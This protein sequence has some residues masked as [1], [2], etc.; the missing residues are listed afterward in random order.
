MKNELLILIPTYNEIKNVEGILL[1]ILGLELPADILFIDDNS[2]DGTGD[3]LERLAIKY[4]NIKILHRKGKLGIGS[5]HMDGINFAYD[6]SYKLL[7]TMDC[8]FSHSPKEIKNFIKTAEKFDIVVGSRFLKKESLKEWNFLRLF[9][10]HIGHIA[11]RL[12]LKMPYDSTGAFRLYR[13]D[14]I[15]RYFLKII[16]SKG[17]SF[18]YESLYVLYCNNYR[19]KEIPI[20]LPARVYGQSKMR[21]KDALQSLLRLIKIF[22]AGKLNSRKFVITEPFIAENQ[23]LDTQGWDGYWQDN[24]KNPTLYIYGL[25]AAFYRIFIIKP[26][27]NH[28]I[29]KYFNKEKKLLHAG[30]GGGQVDIDLS[31]NLRITALDISTIALNQYKKNNPKVE[32]LIHGSILSIPLPSS[33]FDGIYNLGVMEHFTENEI[34]DILKEFRRV[35]K[36]NG[37]IILFWP[38]EYGLSVKF[39]KFAHF[40]LNKILNKKITLHPDEISRIKSYDYIKDICVRADLKLIQYNFGI[41]DFFTYCVI[42][43]SR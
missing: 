14:N 39:L 38:P 43:L 5:A 31:Q 7:I 4:S 2:P 12:I 27:L 25:V 22:F 21:L 30:C 9:L 18:F 24:S 40:V 23:I 41:R 6:H 28:F 42:T 36:P 32:K 15:S 20:I 19:I 13:I 1:E 35:I 10:T 16:R 8:D 17:Y 33:S 37:L 29:F 26:S 34:M 11:T 3:K